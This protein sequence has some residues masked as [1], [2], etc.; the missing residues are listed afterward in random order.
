MSATVSTAGRSARMPS[1]WRRRIGDYASRHRSITIIVGMALFTTLMP[2][3]VMVPP[4][5]AFQ[6]LSPW[7]NGFANAGVFVLLALGLNIV[8]GFA[9]LLDLG[10][11]AFFAIGAYAYAYGASPFSGLHLPFVVLIVVGALAAALFGILL[12]APT[13]RLR[14]D[15]LAI[16]TLGFGEIVPIVFLNLDE[17]TEGTNGIGGI[18]RPSFPLIG[19]FS[20][21]DP[22]PFYIL[23]AVIVT[24][25]LIFVYRLQYSRLG[26]S[27]AAIREDELAAASNGLNTVTVKLLAFALGASTAGLA[28]VFNASKLTIVSPDQF[29]FTVSFTVL[30]M[31]VLGGMGNPWGVAVGAFIVYNIQA[32]LL[33]QLNTFFDTVQVPILSDLDFV[34]YQFLLYGLALVLMML[35][36]PEGLFPSTRRRRELHVEEDLEPEDLDEPEVVGALGEAPGAEADFGEDAN[37][38]PGAGEQGR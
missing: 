36:R 20:F 1:G 9:G 22:W 34:Q 35:L 33:K 3:I 31:V 16:V 21:T 4:F 13:L 29:L 12:G 14:G 30:A 10:Y 32:V 28:G 38:G 2:L 23:M 8:I 27:W 26:R 24:I 17:W 6:G 15:Y 7:I 18:Y 19:E 37:Q 25:T 11:A 5:S